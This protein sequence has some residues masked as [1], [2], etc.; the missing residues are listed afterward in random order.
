MLFTYSAIFASAQDCG[1]GVGSLV[2]VGTRM[3]AGLH[4]G[5]IRVWEAAPG[6]LPMLLGDWQAHDMSVIGLVLADTR[7]SSLGADG[8]IKAWAATTPCDEDANARRDC[9]LRSVAHLSS[10]ASHSQT[11]LEELECSALDHKSSSEHAPGLYLVS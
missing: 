7:V 1:V 3:W 6:V 11:T 2:A 9:T 5:R 10:G 4:D 8:S